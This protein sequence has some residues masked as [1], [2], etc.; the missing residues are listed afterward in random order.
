MS[1][2]WYDGA[3]NFSR[4]LALMATALPVTAV[5]AVSN[6]VFLLLL[7]KPIGEKL[8]RMKIKYGL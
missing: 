5:Y 6:A 4:Y 8:D 3:F 7:A 2:L 1:T